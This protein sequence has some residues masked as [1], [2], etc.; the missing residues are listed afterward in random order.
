MAFISYSS[1]DNH[2]SKK[3][4]RY[5]KSIENGIEFIATEKIHGANFCFIVNEKEIKCGKRSGVIGG[6]EN[7]YGS[8]HLKEKYAEDLKKLFGNLKNDYPAMDY[9]VLHGELFGGFYPHPEVKR[10]SKVSHV[11]KGIWYAPFVDFLA[12][13]LCLHF[14][15]PV[16]EIFGVRVEGEEK[17]DEE[18]EDE[19][20]KGVKVEKIE[21]KEVETEEN[22]TEDDKEI[23]DSIPENKNVLYLSHTKLLSYL[24]T[25]KGSLQAVKI[26]HQGKLDE[27]IQLSPKFQSTIYTYFNLPKLENDNFAEGYVIKQ[28]IDQ[29][30]R[31]PYCLK[32]KAAKFSEVNDYVATIKKFD[33]SELE[34]INN[35]LK[36]IIS[37]LTQNRFD[38]TI[39]KLG[40]ESIV[41]K[42]KGIFV[43]DAIKD[44]VVT[45]NDEEKENFSKYSKSIK[46][47]VIEMVSIRNEKGNYVLKIV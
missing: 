24:E 12:F 42:I 44:Y 46:H 29:F 8:A 39:S 14:P 27:L 37:Y 43:S 31:R 41:E 36:D 16:D 20:E 3:D 22:K 34:I 45:L 10:L 6:T 4:W 13:D 40:K 11:Q 30:K 5:Q 25:L 1:I 18:K 21:E 38:G 47:R 33:A 7:F 2:T 26:L 23:D 28:N 9:Y 17:E 15:S 19:T 32:I 35:F